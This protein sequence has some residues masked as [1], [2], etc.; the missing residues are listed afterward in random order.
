M[1][2]V[3]PRP[4]DKHTLDRIDP[5]G[6]YEP[7]NCR[8]ALPTEQSRNTRRALKVVLRGQ[9][10]PL[11]EVCDALGIP[12]KKIRAWLDRGST[13]AEIVARGISEKTDLDP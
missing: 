11:Y 8:W 4:S 6:D 2:D 13:L 1:E 9:E 10:Y 3:G 7:D 12:Y 5:D